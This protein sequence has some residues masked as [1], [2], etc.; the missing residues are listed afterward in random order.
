MG[1]AR[2]ATATRPTPALRWAP[3]AAVVVSPGAGQRCMNGVALRRRLLPSAG[4]C[5]GGR[6][7]PALT[8]CG[9]GG[10]LCIACD[11]SKASRC[12][13]T[14]ACHAARGRPARGAA[15]RGGAL[16]LRRELLPERLLSG[17]GLRDPV[18]ADLRGRGLDLRDLRRARGQLLGRRRLPLRRRGGLRDRPAVHRQHLRLGDGTSCPSGCCAGDFCLSGD[19]TTSCG[20]GGSYCGPPRRRQ[21]HERQLQRLPHL[22]PGRMLLRGDLQRP[23]AGHLRVGGVACVGCDA[24]RPI[25]ARHRELRLWQ[26]ARCVRRRTALRGRGLRLR[27]HLVPERL[28]RRHDCAL[29]HARAL[30]NGRRG[31][32]DLQPSTADT[33]TAPARA[34]VGPA[35]L[36]AR[37]SGAWAAAASAMPASVPSGCCAG[38]TCLARSLTA[39]A[40][41]GA[42]CARCNLTADACSAGALRVR[43]GRRVPQRG[44]LRRRRVCLRRDL[45]SRR[46][47]FGHDLPLGQ[48]RRPPAGPAGPPARPARAA[49]AP[50]A[51]ARTAI[52]RAVRGAA[53]RA[54]PARP[55]APP[56]RAAPGA[57]PASPATSRAPR[58]RATAGGCRCGAGA[59]CGAGTSC[60][61]GSCVCDALS[62]PTGCC[63]GGA[64]VSPAF[65]S[66]GLGGAACVAC[67]LAQADSCSP[68]TG[69]CRCGNSAPC[70]AGSRCASGAC[71]CD[72]QS[73]AGGCCANGVCKPAS[74]AACGTQGGTCV[75]CDPVRADA[76]SAA[77][78][79]ACGAT[80]A[81]QMGSRCAGGACGLRGARVRART[82]RSRRARDLQGRHQQGQV[83]LRRRR[84]HDLRRQRDCVTVGTTRACQ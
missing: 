3:V 63:S 75:A 23:L 7:S 76:C 40:P 68:V 5:Q 66:C 48:Q 6:E 62:C 74:L 2:A 51:R 10:A 36:A 8:T 14:G 45:V 20:T 33:C 32:H 64:C 37:A 70:G 60:V 65:A 29:G 84:L 9:M 46:L 47:L 26:R 41:S 35:R 12:G 24:S 58:L 52:R 83:R 72:A 19:T 77:G 17:G 44:P 16:H 28:L 31:L 43:S 50:A 69:A 11:T 38:S 39:C 80:D 15:L 54:R 27:S 21:L 82:A 30:R 71:V 18:P 25:A 22:V 55:P 56:W 4:C 42:A 79:C 34:P 81:C 49:A 57:P 1:P 13:P 73:C 67:N 78:V 53:A 61:A 59:A